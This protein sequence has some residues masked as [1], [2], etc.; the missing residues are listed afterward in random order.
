[1]VE[2][3]PAPIPCFLCEREDGHL[4]AYP[5]TAR[6]QCIRMNEC[7]MCVFSLL[8]T[9]RVLSHTQKLY[10]SWVRGQSAGGC[11][12]NSTFPT[13]PKFWL[14]VYEQ[15]E[16]CIALLQKHRKYSTDWAGRVRNWPRLVEADPSLTDGI[17][18]KNYHAVGL[19][20]WKVTQKRPSSLSFYSFVR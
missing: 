1:M 2:R 13:N 9:D 6:P 16:V 5:Y 10:G 19:H 15:G 12:N 4:Q 8:S 3:G 18:G 7:V 17:R 14:K 20:I 11:R